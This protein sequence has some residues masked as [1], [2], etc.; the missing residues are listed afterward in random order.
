MIEKL[1]TQLGKSI[2]TQEI[3]NLYKDF[4]AEYPKTI[5][6]TANNDTIKGKIE[7]DGIKLYMR[8]GGYSKFLKPII[9]KKAGSFI[10]LFTMIEITKK[11]KGELPHGVKY[12]MASKELTSILG[13]PK[14]VDFMGTTTTWRN[15]ITDK[16]ELIVSDSKGTS[17]NDK[18]IRSITISFLFEQDLYTNEDYEKAGL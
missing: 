12:D 5:T 7:K 1:I 10:G 14:E 16:H 11:Y 13:E 3:K 18:V 2:E 17:P 6:C 8:R 9:G 15:N 4:G